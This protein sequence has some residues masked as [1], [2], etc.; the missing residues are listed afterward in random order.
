[1]IT[2]Q[3]NVPKHSIFFS[4]RTVTHLFGSMFNWGGK[5]HA[6][7]NVDEVIREASHPQASSEGESEPW[8]PTPLTKNKSIQSNLQ[9]PWG[10]KSPKARRK[11]KSWRCQPLLKWKAWRGL[12]VHLLKV[13]RGYGWSWAPPLQ[14]SRRGPTSWAARREKQSPSWL[15]KSAVSGLQATKKP[16]RKFTIRLK[17]R[18]WANRMLWHSG[19]NCADTP[20]SILVER[21][22][23]LI[24]LRSSCKE[25]KKKETPCWKGEQQRNHASSGIA[26]PL[27]L[28]AH[29]CKGHARD[30]PWICA[31]PCSKDLLFNASLPSILV[32]RIHCSPCWKDMVYMEPWVKSFDS[33]G[34][35]CWKG[36]CRHTLVKGV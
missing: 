29:Q 26:H 14:E 16:S 8:P 3:V 7:E 30:C 15:W 10:S 28:W 5:F 13:T 31:S 32:E 22:V 2:A 36:G 11:K 21:I 1:M 27:A 17:K 6:L 18:T 4:R 34:D 25:R 19:V 35:P 24:S 12:H 33:F 23:P 20:A 9:K